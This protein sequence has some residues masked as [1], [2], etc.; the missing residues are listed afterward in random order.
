MTGTKIGQMCSANPGWMLGP[1]RSRVASFVLIEAPDGKKRV[2]CLI[3]KDAEPFLVEARALIHFHD[4][5]LKMPPGN[6]GRRR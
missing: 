3:V 4:S 6:R 2:T 1:E 5:E